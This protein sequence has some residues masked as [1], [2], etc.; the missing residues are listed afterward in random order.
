MFN[1]IAADQYKPPSIVNRCSVGNGQAPV[2]AAATARHA[3]TGQH[4]VQHEEQKDDNQ[5]QNTIDNPIGG[6]GGEAKNVRTK[7]LVH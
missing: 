4:L 6:F 2:F 3:W 1:I 5:G 7:K